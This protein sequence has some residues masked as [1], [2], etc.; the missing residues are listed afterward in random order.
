MQGH[1]RQRDYLLGLEDKPLMDEFVALYLGM[2]GNKSLEKQ[3]RESLSVSH[4]SDLPFFKL[5]ET[6]SS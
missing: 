1:D 6:F 2:A 3:F 5:S 4:E